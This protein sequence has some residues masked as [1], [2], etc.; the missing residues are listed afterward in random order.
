MVRENHSHLTNGKRE[1]F[2][3]RWCNRKKDLSSKCNFHQIISR[4]TIVK[5]NKYLVDSNQ[6]K[7]DKCGR[8]INAQISPQD[9]CSNVWTE[10]WFIKVNVRELCHQLCPIS[11][12]M[13]SS[14][15]YSQCHRNNLALCELFLI[16]QL[17]AYIQKNSIK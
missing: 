4:S 11:F 6:F 17:G 5:L 1:S 8:Q 16:I 13:R 9:K 14:S 12:R 15:N 7:T 2:I 10:G 3:K